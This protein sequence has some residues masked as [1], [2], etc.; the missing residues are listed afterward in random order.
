MG[1]VEVD[2]FHRTEIQT[3]QWKFFIKFDEM[4]K[5]AANRNN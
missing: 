3:C 2:I 4:Q 5:S 1:E